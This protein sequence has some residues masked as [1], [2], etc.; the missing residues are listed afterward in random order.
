M[1]T[2]RIFIASFIAG[3]A[4]ATKYE[5]IRREFEG[6]VTGRWEP[7]EKLHLTYKFLG[8]VPS[9]DVHLL[10]DALAGVIGP[11]PQIEI[12]PAGIGFFT[13]SAPRI[14]YLKISDR[15]NALTELASKIEDAMAGI[16]FSRE[17]RKFTPHATLMRLKGVRQPAF[18]AAVKKHER[19][20]APVAKGISVDLVESVLTP[21]G[22][23]YATVSD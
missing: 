15:A 20:D 7:A 9:E 11:H 19:F 14:L 2:K 16:G 13:P 17:E 6:S 18:S 8:D 1:G 5:E 22:S 3:A 10:R 12:A 4:F 23:V 21:S